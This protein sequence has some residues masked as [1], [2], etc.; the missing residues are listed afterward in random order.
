MTAAHTPGPWRISRGDVIADTKD[1]T[2]TRNV[3]RVDT[4]FP[5]N[6]ANARLIAAA[7]EM[8]AALNF[9]LNAPDDDPRSVERAKIQAA[10]AITKA[11][12][13]SAS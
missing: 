12:E 4:G 10:V 1:G 11:E 8:L 7:P 3:A 6:D 5:E 2:A 13:G 9:L